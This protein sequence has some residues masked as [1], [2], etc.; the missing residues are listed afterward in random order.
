MA[1]TLQDL[2]S[3]LGI[4]VS[5]LKPEVATKWNGYLS[6]ADTKYAAATAAQKEA[7]E[8]LAQLKIENDAINDQIAK[9]GM[10][11]NTVNAL[12]ANY[13]A[14]EA[15]LKA[16][17]EAGMDVKVPDALPAPAAPDPNEQFR[18]NVTRGFAQMG[19]AV[20]LINRYQ[21]VFSK[22]L[23]DD[24]DALA[25]EASARKMSL[26]AYAEQKYNF[27]AEQQRIA[28]EQ[29]KKHD[30]EVAAAAIKKY[31]EEHPVT[32]GNP[33]FARGVPSRHPQ[34]VKPREATESKSFANLPMRQK[35]AQ[36]V[37]RTRAALST[38]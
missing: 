31:Q 27:A 1:F 25:S 28:A 7:D 35:I 36:S 18:N 22:P 12:R 15:Q 9:F 38:T 8:K 21:Q 4:D 30:D 2:A 33:E 19:E 16:L 23:P 3:E 5:T 17:K 14:M 6:E 10:T 32:Q 11:E 20:K 24:L 37:A 26:M 13:A 34:L 29:Q